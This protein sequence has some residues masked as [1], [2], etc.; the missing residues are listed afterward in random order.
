MKAF[1]FSRAASPAMPSGRSGIGEF[2]LSRDWR[3]GCVGFLTEITVGYDKHPVTA[4]PTPYIIPAAVPEG[5]TG[6][7]LLFG[8]ILTIGSAKRKSEN[9]ICRKM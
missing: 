2:S 5:L 7:L 9:R 3:T 8:V 4:P 6:L 1:A